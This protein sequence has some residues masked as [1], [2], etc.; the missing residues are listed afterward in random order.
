MLKN[1]Q[2]FNAAQ[3]YVIITE[4]CEHPKLSGYDAA[5]QLLEK[6]RERFC[7]YAAESYLPK[8]KDLTGW[9]RVDRTL[10][11]MRERTATATAEEHFQ[12]VG[13]LGRECLI[14]IAQMV[15][16]PYM[17]P[18]EIDFTI[19]NTDAKRMFEAFLDHRLREE[20]GRVKKCCKAAFDLANHVTHKR[21]ATMM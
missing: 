17:A 11:E 6:T 21:N 5:S 12:T 10:E 4:L 7:C 18:G 2:A 9:Q 3:Q 14:T 13:M 15:Y 19:S 8:E 1:L 16:K 20:D